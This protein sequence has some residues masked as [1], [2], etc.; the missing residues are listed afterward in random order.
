MDNNDANNILFQQESKI[1][2]SEKWRSGSFRKVMAHDLTIAIS[3]CT[4]FCS[5]LLLAVESYSWEV[6]KMAKVWVDIGDAR[7]CDRIVGV[8]KG[9]V[10][11]SCNDGKTYEIDPYVAE[12]ADKLRAKP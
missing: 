7:G 9:K 11:Y 8:S 4:F 3:L 6:E 1:S 2:S 12:R 10:I 5:L